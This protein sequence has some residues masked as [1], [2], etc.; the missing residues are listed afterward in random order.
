MMSQKKPCPPE[1]GLIDSFRDDHAFLSN[2]YPAKL[3]YGGIAYRNAEAAYQA[4]KCARPKDRE[5]FSMLSADEA[6]RRGRQVPLRPD[7]DRER[8]GVMEGVLRAKFDQNPRLA[9]WL[10]ETGDMLLCEGNRWRDVFWGIDLKTRQGENRLGQLLMALRKRYREHGLPDGSAQRPIRT[11]GPIQ[12][13]SV[14]DEAIVD[15][16]VECIV[17]ATDNRLTADSSVS[18]DIYRVGGPAFLRQCQSI[19]WCETGGAV[20]T[21]GDALSTQ[22]VIH[23]AGPVCQRDD[24]ALLRQC[25]CRCMDLAKEAGIRRIAFPP[26]STGRFCFPKEMA[27]RYAVEALLNWVEENPDGPI[28]IILSCEDALIFEETCD[29]LRSLGRK[30]TEPGDWGTEPMEQPVKR[31]PLRGLVLTAKEYRRLSL[32]L[33]PVEMEDKWFLYHQDDQLFC[34]RSWTGQCDYIVEF[35]RCEEGY[36]AEAF[37][38][39]EKNTRDISERAAVSALVSFLAGN[40]EAQ[41]RYTLQ[42]Q[43]LAC[44]I[45]KEALAGLML[46][47]TF[48]AQVL[49]GLGAF[50]ENVEPDDEENRESAEPSSEK[51]ICYEAA[52]RSGLYG[53]CVADALGVPAEFRSR[54]SLD[55]EP[56]TGM[57]GGGAHDQPAGTWSDDSSMTL[58]LADSLGKSGGVHTHDIMN[59]FVG[60][61]QRGDYAAGGSCFDI[62]HTTAQA[63]LRYQAGTT[64]ALCGGNKDHANGNGSL[65][66]ILPL[67][68]EL[69]AAYGA[70]IASSTQA[71][72][73]IHKVSGL[74]HRHPVAQSACGIYVCIA[75]RLLELRWEVGTAERVLKLGHSGVPY[76]RNAEERLRLNR[77]ILEGTREAMEWYDIHQRFEGVS[78]R[79]ERLK[80]MEKLRSMPRSEV[81]SGG[82]VVDTLEAA[83]WC[84]LNTDTYADCVLEAVSL[85]RDTDTTAAVVGGLAGL[86]YGYDAVPEAWLEVLKGRQIIDSCCDRLSGRY[87]RSKEES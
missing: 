55:E 19:G 50:A 12:G 4:Q 33:I 31:V 84:L 72:S 77:A 41:E 54:A 81:N 27:A 23:T 47:S 66:R 40:R 57:V 17:N 32:G 1:R 65:M 67:A 75:A 49:A 56:I 38:M 44:P 18:G 3:Y 9:R 63:L 74:T 2:F 29:S 51:E 7:W 35:A 58:C 68:Y 80:D 60:W 87:R 13:I 52:I 10:L 30:K 39:P 73:E 42:Y 14:T 76:R 22:Y 37:L 15:L 36:R 16:Q 8:I 82:Y 46:Y 62:G 71:M 61:W 64:P 5:Q 83:L 26:I 43:T 85:G 45:G 86:A 24:P 34:H 6:K 53:V 48:G 21:A 28:D 59:R 79:W 25:Y 11:F 69:Y 20:L 70:H 78:A